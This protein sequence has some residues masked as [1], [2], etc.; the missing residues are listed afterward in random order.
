[1]L[2]FRP[3]WSRTPKID[4]FVG[5]GSME[6]KMK[7]VFDVKR[8]RS[9]EDRVGFTSFP[10]FLG[11]VLDWGTKMIIM[12]VFTTS[13]LL[14][15]VMNLTRISE[16]EGGVRVAYQYDM[17]VRQR[18]AQALERGETEEV[19]GFL[20]CV[21]KDDISDAKSKLERRTQETA[22]ASNDKFGG[23][24][25]KG[26]PKGNGQS[27]GGGSGSA[28][29]LTGGR[30]RSPRGGKPNNDKGGKGGKGGKGPTQRK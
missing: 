10:N 22:R 21:N 13:D 17:L 29:K 28:S 20:L 25:G 6:D 30:S 11:H 7:A 8:A 9:A 19:H 15:Y 12:K 18:M 14:A 3:T 5:D 24:A 23:K 16:E 2:N 1:M 27:W 26:F 4:V